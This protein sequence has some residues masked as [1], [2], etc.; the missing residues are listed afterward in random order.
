VGYDPTNRRYKNVKALHLNRPSGRRVNVNPSLFS[1]DRL[2][3]AGLGTPKNRSGSLSEH[4]PNLA[5]DMERALGALRARPA[6]I[7]P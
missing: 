2:T 3:P 5:P 4:A 7:A 1:P 6:S